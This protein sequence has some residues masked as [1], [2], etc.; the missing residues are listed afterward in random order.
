MTMD[1]SH[2]GTH[3]LTVLKERIAKR[4]AI[5]VEKPGAKQDC[6]MKPS[7]N[8]ARQMT[9]SPRRQ[10]QLGMFRRYAYKDLLIKEA[11]L[12]ITLLWYCISC[13]IT[14]MSDE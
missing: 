7:F 9:S 3:S 4:F 12:P 6:A 2:K 10:S 14:R 13:T 8:S 5:M 11:R 1:S